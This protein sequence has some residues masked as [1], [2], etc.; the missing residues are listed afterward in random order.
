M[1]K[2]LGM[3]NKAVAADAGLSGVGLYVTAWGRVDAVGGN[4][5][6]LTDGSG[7]SLKVYAPSGYSA[8]AGDYVKVIGALGAEL[9]GTDAV[10][11]LRAVSVTK[12][13]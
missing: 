7:A 12:A 6:T 13:D 2:P 4:P 11:V 9:S 10:S 5:F 3:N 1:P 8:I